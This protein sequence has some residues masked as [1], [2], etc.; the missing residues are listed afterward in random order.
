M[1][2]HLRSTRRRNRFNH[3]GC[4]PRRLAAEKLEDR[5]VLATSYIAHDLVSNQPGVAPLTDPTLLNG[6]GIALSPTG[7]TI[8]V[9]SN[10]GGVS[11]LYTGDVN[12]TPLVKNP[13]L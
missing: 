2:A 8:W 7:P 13:G 3:R 9:S 10:G 5:L 11:E 4:G 6:W 1:T 12:G